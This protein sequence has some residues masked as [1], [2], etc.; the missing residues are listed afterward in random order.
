MLNNNF[1]QNNALVGLIFPLDSVNTQPTRVSNFMKKYKEIPSGYIFGKL[2]VLRFSHSDN[3]YAYFECVCECGEITV[4]TGQRLRSGNTTS[5]GCKRKLSIKKI[6]TTHGLSKT[7]EYDIWTHMKMRCMNPKDKKYKDYGG[8]GIKVCDRWSGKNGFENFF[9]DMGNKPTRGHSIDRKD[10]NGDYEPDNCRWATAKEQCNNTR[11]NVILEYNGEKHNIEQWAKKIGINPA[12]I[13]SRLDKGWDIKSSL[14]DPPIRRYDFNGK[15]ITT[16]EFAE[17]TAV[18]HG[19]VYYRIRQ[20]WSFDKI[21][22]YYVLK[23]D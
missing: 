19:I 6:R 5:C 21:Y 17:I 2:K 20:K 15:S 23:N 13:W 8:R 3:T 10:N 4:V 14:F 18:S 16:K 22:K 11:R 7:E 12:T 9:S 1:I